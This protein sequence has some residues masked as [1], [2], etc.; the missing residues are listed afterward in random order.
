VED[1]DDRLAI[2]R[3]LALGLV[4][5]KEIAS[6]LIEKL[7]Y[8]HA[9]VFGDRDSDLAVSWLGESGEWTILLLRI[10]SQW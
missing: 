8:R 6:E 4:K 9:L 2:W 10:E 5:A 7:A 1:I 3:A